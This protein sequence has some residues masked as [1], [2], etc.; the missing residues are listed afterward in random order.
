MYF[1]IKR[2]GTKILCP[3]HFKKWGDMSP[4]PSLKLGPW[5]SGKSV[6]LWAVNSRLITRR[7]KPI[8]L[9]LTFTTVKCGE[10]AGKCISFA[11]GKS[12]SRDSSILGW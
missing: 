5:L 9:K 10:Q 4:G 3:P 1:G 6:R 12:S 7:V 8:T 11:V 2:G